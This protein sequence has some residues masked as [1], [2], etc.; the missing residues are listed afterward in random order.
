MKIIFEHDGRKTTIIGNDYET[1][2]G[3]IRSLFPNENHRRIQFYDPELTD[4]FE[5]TSYEQVL[6]Q[7]N[8]IKMNFDLSNTSQSIDNCHVQLSTSETNANNISKSAA[9]GK[10][11][12]KKSHK[13]LP[14]DQQ[15]KTIFSIEYFYS[16]VFGKV[17]K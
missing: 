17:S 6:D 8:G 2:T 12:T 5:F 15:V 7:P 14:N 16:R 11:P 3:K 13:S 4:H 9:K 10:N 1:I